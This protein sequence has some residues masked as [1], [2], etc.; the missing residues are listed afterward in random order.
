MKESIIKLSWM[1]KWKTTVIM[2]WV[3]GNERSWIDVFTKLLNTIEINNW[4]VFFVFWNPK[5]IEKNVRFLEKN[6]NRCFHIEINWDTYEDNRAKTIIKILNKSDY[7]LDIHNTINKSKP[8]LISERKDLDKYFPVDKVVSW[9]DKLHPWWSDGYMNSIWK[10]G[11]CIECWNIGNKTWEKIAEESIINFL[12]FTWNI[13]WKP[14]LYKGK[15]H[16]N[17]YEIYKT[18]TDNFRLN[19]EFNEFEGIR[20]WEIIWYDWNE[21]IISKKDWVMLFAYAANK[22]WSEGFTMW[23]KL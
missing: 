12:K 20:K 4:T 18:K 19:R 5:A 8:F 1:K 3:H 15:D 13:E 23:V 6:L 7:L 11:L 16:F 14:I 17:F 9:F 2:T 22:I 21:C 10:V